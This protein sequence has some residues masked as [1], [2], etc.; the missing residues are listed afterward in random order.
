[1]QNAA[2][3]MHERALNVPMG[4]FRHGVMMA[5]KRFK[6]SWAELG[7]LLVKVHDDGS[8]QEWGYDSFETYCYKELRIRKQTA[9]KLIRSFGFL[10]KHEPEAVERDD[11]SEMAPAFEVV[12]VLAHAEDA[13][14]LSE[15]EYKQV[16]DSIWNSAR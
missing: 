3:Q 11:F 4:S 13:G 7:K 5:A 14:S 6:S 16:R 9:Y 15:S 10:K 1:M 8:F 2:E 12:E